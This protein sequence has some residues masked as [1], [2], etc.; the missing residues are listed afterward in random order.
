M[1]TV[2]KDVLSK[3]NK[4][5]ETISDP[6]DRAEIYVKIAN[7]IALSGLISE[8]SATEKPATKKDKKSEPAKKPEPVKETK[9]TE[10][11]KTEAN[12]EDVPF[13]PEDA[14]INDSDKEWT[15]EAIQKYAKE[16]EALQKA[17]EIYG[18]EAMSEVVELFSEGLYKSIEDINPLN[19]VG[20][21]AYVESLQAEE[22]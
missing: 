11:P 15:E 5:A 18:E 20:F 3:A 21:M 6:K 2:F 14:Q 1:K 17:K 7:A 8:E 16:I 19:I 4:L 10:E 12:E 13:N 22:E 9:P